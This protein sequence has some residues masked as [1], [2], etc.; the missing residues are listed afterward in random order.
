MLSREN[1]LSLFFSYFIFM[2][3]VYVL[4]IIQKSP[5]LFL[6]FLYDFVN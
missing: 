6:K 3:C 2:S 1:S 5:F 4:N